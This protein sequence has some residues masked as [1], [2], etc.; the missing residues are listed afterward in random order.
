MA[1]LGTVLVS[2]EVVAEVFV[3]RDAHFFWDR[4]VEFSYDCFVCR[5]R[6]RTVRLRHGDEEGRC[7]SQRKPPELIPRGVHSFEEVS[8]VHPAPIRV[9]GFNTAQRRDQDRDRYT[10]RCQIRYWWAPFD[11]AKDQEPAT[12][13]TDNPWV[14]IHYGLGCRSCDRA[15]REDG[16]TSPGQQSIQTNMV[17]PVVATCPTCERTLLT[18]ETGPTITLVE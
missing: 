16:L 14:R 12:T 6:R 18:A 15:G 5:R 3:G 17:W 8:F 2:V 13:L 10:L 9:T 11:D 7:V 4:A 1:I